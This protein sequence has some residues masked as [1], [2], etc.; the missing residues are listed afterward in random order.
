MGLGNLGIAL[1]AAT[2]QMN[3][4]QEEQDRKDQF[5]QHMD[6]QRDS[7]NLQ[8]GEIDRKNDERTRANQVWANAQNVFKGGVDAA[9]D[10]LVGRYNQQDAALGYDDDHKASWAKDAKGN[11]LV[12]RT[13]PDGKTVGTQVFTPQQVAQEHLG[14]I[15]SDLA[16]ISPEHAQQYS[17]W[18]SDQAKEGTRQRERG[19]DLS[20]RDKREG[21]EDER[22]GKDYKLRQQQVGQAGVA[23]QLARDR[24]ALERPGLVNNGAINTQLYG[25]R[26]QLMA[27]TDPTKQEDLKRQMRALSTT[28]GEHMT[29]KVIDDG[30]GGKVMVAD[31]GNGNL[32]R[33]DPAGLSDYKPKGATPGV[34]GAPNMVYDPK[35]G[36]LVPVKR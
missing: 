17:N 26:Q 19:E 35:T 23:N 21:V 3:K 31:D 8:K 11:Y 20:H 27:E 5:K 10:H 7:F 36:K 34:A 29:T 22:W 16:A 28:G 13:G 24:F 12:T 9:A 14:S 15:Y 30:Q 18:L 1:G 32:Y 2:Q 25:L 4:D 6:L 33:V